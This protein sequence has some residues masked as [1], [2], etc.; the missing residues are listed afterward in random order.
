VIDGGW[1]LLT[2]NLVV[3]ENITLD[4]VIA[5]MADWFD[6]TATDG[7]L[8]A[9]NVEHREAADALVL[10]R[11]TYQEFEGCRPNQ[12]DDQTGISGYLNHS[13]VVLLAYRAR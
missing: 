4:G 8:L 13:G 12:V 1:N 11:V 10:G 2:R 3:T 9:A 7:A 5:P 6:P